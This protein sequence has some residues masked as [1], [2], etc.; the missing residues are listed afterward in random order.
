M[1]SNATSVSLDKV[2]TNET[3]SHIIIFEKCVS[4][5]GWDDCAEIKTEKECPFLADRCTWQI[6][7]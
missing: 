7:S 6:Q 2:Q 3:A 5:K 4:T 1:T